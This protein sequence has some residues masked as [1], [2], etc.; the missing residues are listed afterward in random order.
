MHSLRILGT[1]LL[2]FFLGTLYAVL[3]GLIAGSLRAPL[4]AWP[5][6]IA[7]F[8]FLF[9]KFKLARFAG[10]LLILP[11]CVIGFEL[12]WSAKNEQPSQNRSS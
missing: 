12:I 1:F 4:I 10:F 2:A 3:V 8:W 11:V 6:W 7:L 9:W 5:V